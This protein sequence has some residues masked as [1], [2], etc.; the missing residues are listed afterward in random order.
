MREITELEI[1][2]NL[3]E[4][5]DYVKNL[6][7]ASVAGE[8]WSISCAG[9]ISPLGLDICEKNAIHLRTLHRTSPPSYWNLQTTQTIS[10]MRN[11]WDDYSPIVKELSS[12]GST[13]EEI[14]WSDPSCVL[15]KIDFWDVVIS[16]ETHEQQLRISRSRFQTVSQNSIEDHQYKIVT[17]DPNL[18]VTIQSE[19]L[20][21]IKRQTLKGF[22]LAPCSN[23]T[24]QFIPIAEGAAERTGLMP[25]VHFITG[26]SI[27][28]Q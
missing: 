22:E 20:S 24:V 13:A 23:Y 18:R 12:N 5:G 15:L 11:R 2:L 6:S 10:A 9:N 16:N 25:V 14:E 8:R 17:N 27:F 26:L 28:I 4:S 19:V 3:K 21:N 1:V 7:C